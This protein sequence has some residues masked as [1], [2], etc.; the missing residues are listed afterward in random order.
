[1]G[2]LPDNVNHFPCHR[3]GK[4]IVIPQPIP[5]ATKKY[6]KDF[7]ESLGAI[8]REYDSVFGSR[9]WDKGKKIFRNPVKKMNATNAVDYFDRGTENF[10]LEIVSSKKAM[11]K[12]LIS[13]GYFTYCPCGM[14]CWSQRLFD[15]LAHYTIPI[16]AN[17]GAVMPFERFMDWTKFTIK[18]SET[19]WMEPSNRNQFRRLLRYHVDIFRK[20]LMNCFTSSTSKDNSQVED[21][22]WFSRKQLDHPGCQ[23]L[24]KTLI[25]KKRKHYHRLTRWFDFP[26][27]SLKSSPNDIHAFRLLTLEMWCRI[28][29]QNE[30]LW[31]KQSK[32][33]QQ[34]CRRPSD[35]TARF[36]YL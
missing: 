11:N 12:R 19:T 17:D 13:Q 18:M 35:S 36:E 26:D 32:N 5:Y 30:I 29:K 7:K 15:A 20:E 9:V 2:N 16:L 22:N 28:C 1:M 25:W 31:N 14:T 4:D 21:S 27:Q 10:H 8:Y 24:L 23:S 6:S 3:P 34:A 33:M